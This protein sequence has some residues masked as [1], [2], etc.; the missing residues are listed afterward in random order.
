MDP[1][2]VDYLEQFSSDDKYFTHTSMGRGARKY[3]IDDEHLGEFYNLY[4]NILRDGGRMSLLEKP[5]DTIPLIV[6][7]DLRSRVKQNRLYTQEII[8][9]VIK[10][11]QEIIE[12]I[13]LDPSEKTFYCCVLEKDNSSVDNNGRTKDGFHLHFPFFVTEEWVQN[14]YIRNRVIEAVVERKIFKQ[15]NLDEPATRIFDSSIPRN[16]WFLY[17]GVKW[18]SN[19]NSLPWK[20]TKIYDKEMDKLKPKN[21]FKS[22]KN[23]DGTKIK[24][25]DNLSYHLSIR[26]NQE[27]TPLVD[28]IKKK[29]VVVTKHKPRCKRNFDVVLEELVESKTFIKMLSQD[30]CD[31]FY[32]WWEMGCVLYSIGEGCDQALE[33]WRDW[34][35][36]SDHYEEGCCE[37]FWD[38]ME[39]RNYT[40]GTI[41]YFAQ[42]DSPHDFRNYKNEKVSGLLEQGISMSHNDIAQI[43]YLLYEGRFTC[44]DAE[45]ELWYEFRGHRWIRCQRAITLRKLISK[46]LVIKYSFMTADLMRTIQSE[47][48]NEYDRE[49]STSKAALVTKLMDKLKNNSFKNCVLKEAMEYFYDEKFVERMDENEHLLVFENGVYDA[50][51]KMFRDGR[52]DDYCTKTTGLYYNEYDDDDYR[53]KEM[54]GIFRKTFPNKN[55]FKFFEQTVSDLVLGGNRHKIFCIWNGDGDN[56]K[57]IIAEMLDKAFGD[58]YYTPPTTL[59]TGKQQQSSGCTPELIPC[60]GSKVV[61][62]SETDNADIL[63]CGTMKKL[64][65][66]DAFFARG[67]IKD[68]IKIIPHFKLIL[69][70]NKLPNVSADDKASWNRIRVLQFESTFVN[71]EDAPESEEEQWRLKKF[72]KDKKLKDRIPQMSEVFIWWLINRYE[73]YGDADLF[74]PEE[75]R[76]AT[77]HYHRNNDFYMQFIDDQLVKTGNEKEDVLNM[78][79]IHSL[80]KEWYRDSYPG[81]TVPSRPQLQD[82]LEKRMGKSVKNSWRGWNIRS[83]DDTTI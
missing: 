35:Q 15:M 81:K 27:L 44:A 62:I 55:L 21:V 47:E 20:L 14:K 76:S 60:K 37:R 50:K 72:P 8:K 41:K 28:S 13:A 30:R 34:S 24:I 51:M 65:G 66:G 74:M 64:T 7:V 78:T 63:N 59:L 48:T 25:S 23:D 75:V 33:I 11:Y 43:L 6:D 53:V 70:C 3:Y 71:K 80:F 54:I 69:H 79:I 82:S 39:V 31:D 45:K 56:G 52:P 40:I 16:C 68:P 9:N 5:Q 77:N 10:I 42:V 29:D 32:G 83:E 46:E 17:G 49:R 58:Y 22:I 73:S 36:L 2:I 61:Q 1:R 67:L 26:G 57:S 19:K 12:D 38:K 4:N 18:P